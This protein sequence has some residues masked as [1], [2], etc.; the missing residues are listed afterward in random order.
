MLKIIVRGNPKLYPIMRVE[1]FY[2]FPPFTL[3]RVR[4]QVLD[5]Y[6]HKQRIPIMASSMYPSLKQ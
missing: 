6:R 2:S 1:Y 5:G 3:I 4:I